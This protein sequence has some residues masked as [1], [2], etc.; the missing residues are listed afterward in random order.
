MNTTLEQRIATVLSS[1][2]TSDVVAIL[3]TEVETAIVAADNAAEAEREKALDP[4]AS[5]DAAKAHEAMQMVEF[6]RDRLRTAL[7]RLQAR[8]EQLQAEEYLTQWRSD[9]EK[10]KVKRDGL[11]EELRAI[12]PVF[13]TKI[14]DL[15]TRIAANDAEL[16][17]LH[18]ARPGGVA[19]HLLGAELV[20]RDLERFRSLEPS[21]AQELKLPTFAPG[22]RLAWPPSQPALAVMV[23]Q[24]MAPPHDPRFS[25]DWAAAQKEDNIRR[26]ATEKRWA[27]EEVARQAESRRAYE[28]SLRR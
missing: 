12:Y 26:A 24:S 13:E 15:L 17:R 5:P 4:I 8:L 28:A 9:Y 25:A 18:Q 21:I 16:S 22:Q 19:L 2:T 23:A 11:A 27:E 3:I 20:A 7:P 1:D 14:T 6:S 10:L